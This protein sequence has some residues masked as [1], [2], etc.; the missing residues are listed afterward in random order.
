MS[1][2]RCV[3]TRIVGKLYIFEAY[4]EFTRTTPA[5]STTYYVEERRMIRH[6]QKSSIIPMIDSRESSYMEERVPASADVSDDFCSVQGVI[7]AWIG[8]DDFWS[9]S[10]DLLLI[11]S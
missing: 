3:V 11:C 10:R 6:K 5:Q 2:S 9:A 7:P 4:M 8:R 1:K